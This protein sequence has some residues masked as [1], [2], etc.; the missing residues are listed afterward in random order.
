M[1]ILGVSAFHHDSAAALL[2][3]NQ[4]VGASQ[5]ER[6]SRKKYDK[7]W[8]QHTIQWLKH[9]SDDITTVAF[10]DKDNIQK[11]FIA[12]L[13]KRIIENLNFFNLRFEKLNKNIFNEF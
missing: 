11:S 7:R 13:P 12:E 3:N 2:K 9:L 8:P 10:Y 4:I 5:E 1:S 6:F